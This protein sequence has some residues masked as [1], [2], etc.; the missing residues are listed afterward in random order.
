MSTPIYSSAATPAPLNPQPDLNS[1]VLT[2]I[3]ELKKANDALRSQVQ[4]L[5]SAQTVRPSVTT[6]EHAAGPALTKAPVWSQWL[7]ELSR[8]G[9][10]TEE[11]LKGVGIV[12]EDVVKAVI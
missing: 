1:E 3:E 7:Q 4:S 12:A 9:G 8:N 10:L 6:P 5:Q 11:I 2:Q